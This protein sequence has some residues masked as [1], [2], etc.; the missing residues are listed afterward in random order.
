MTY[1]EYME[2]VH[3]QRVT[4]PNQPLLFHKRVNFTKYVPLFRETE[5]KGHFQLS[6]LSYQIERRPTFLRLLPEFVNITGIRADVCQVKSFFFHST[7]K[8]SLSSK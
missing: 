3:N 5:R 1:K 4:I 7:L 2:K 8:F 6:R